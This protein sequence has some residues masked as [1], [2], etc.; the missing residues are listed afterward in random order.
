MHC[1]LTG[2]VSAIGRYG[3][4]NVILEIQAQMPSTS[5]KDTFKPYMRGVYL[6]YAIVSWCYFGVAFT[7]VL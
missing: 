7:G 2:S 1:K 3:G 4:H 6:A 5:P